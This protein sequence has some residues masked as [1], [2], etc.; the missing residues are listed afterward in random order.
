MSCDGAVINKEYAKNKDDAAGP[1][2][3][4]LS[5]SGGPRPSDP[6]REGGETKNKKQ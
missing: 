3:I 6:A 4:D 2:N 1:N 5:V